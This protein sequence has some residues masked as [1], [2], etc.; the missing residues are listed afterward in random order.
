MAIN[1]KHANVYAD[2]AEIASKNAEQSGH[3]S[4][5]QIA[6]KWHSNAAM[7]YQLGGDKTK[8]ESMRHSADHD[9]AWRPI[10]SILSHM[11]YGLYRS[12]AVACQVVLAF[13]C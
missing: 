8:E 10:L 11:P 3:F 6:S 5:H 4:D 2:T 7:A 9:S 1:P 13:E 12:V